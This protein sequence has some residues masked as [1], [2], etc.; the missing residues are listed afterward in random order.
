TNTETSTTT[1]PPVTITTTLPQYPISVEKSIIIESTLRL[2]AAGFWP[3]KV[4]GI[5]HNVGLSIG[6][7]GDAEPE[8]IAIVKEVIDEQAPGLRLDT[9]INIR[10]SSLYPDMLMEAV[11]HAGVAR[12]QSAGL[13]PRYDNIHPDPHIV[14]GFMFGI[15]GIDL[16]FYGEMEPQAVSIVREVIDRLAPGLPLNILENVV[17]VE[18]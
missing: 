18:Q 17:F 15:R 6:F 7:F 3:E 12:L 2:E 1:L 8:A 5:V 13:M 11:Y 16:D 14:A 4:S 10:P 9:V